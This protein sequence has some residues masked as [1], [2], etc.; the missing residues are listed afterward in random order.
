MCF[1]IAGD[2]HGTLDIGKVVWFIE[3]REDE[4]SKE[5]YLII[6]GD[7]LS[8]LNAYLTSRTLGKGIEIFIIT[9]M[10]AYG[11]NK[12][13]NVIESEKE[14]VSKVLEMIDQ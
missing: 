3:G 6:C 8:Y 7:D 13:Y 4:F 12:P 5:D 9:S 11:E 2:T 14:F 10:D 1:I